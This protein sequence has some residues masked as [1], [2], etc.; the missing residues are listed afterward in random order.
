MF[1]TRKIREFLQL[2]FG[3][4]DDMMN[5]LEQMYLETSLSVVLHE[6]LKYLRD[7]NHTEDLE[8]INSIAERAGD[9]AIDSMEKIMEK[10]GEVYF[11]Y[12]EL[13]KKIELEIDVFDQS[14]ISDMLENLND[15]QYIK[16]LEMGIEDM[17]NIK[18]LQDQIAL[19]RKA[20]EESTSE[21]LDE[22]D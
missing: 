12:P 14:L 18:K 3:Y 15:E 19:N 10:V 1:Y 9:E 17:K 16:L 5:Y 20:N 8:Y 2:E 6:S 21:D 7:N 22:L 11:K 13:N 4:T